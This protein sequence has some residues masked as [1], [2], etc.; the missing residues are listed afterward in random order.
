VVV[1]GSTSGGSAIVLTDFSSLAGQADWR[2]VTG[3]GTFFGNESGWRNA[4]SAGLTRAVIR[5]SDTGAFSGDVAVNFSSGSGAKTITWP[6]G[7]ASREIYV[8]VN[9][10]TTG[11]YPGT[12]PAGA[13]TGQR[14]V[15][16]N[17]GEFDF[18]VQTTGNISVFATRTVA[19]GE[20]IVLRWS[21][22]AWAA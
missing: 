18:T 15:L 20:T 8:A 14:L 6:T 16:S 7:L 13:I 5:R 10:T 22:S 9:P 19:V 4:G 21:G 1:K 11:T 17:V 2:D 3:D 12:I